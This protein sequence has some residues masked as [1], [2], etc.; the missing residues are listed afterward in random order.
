MK[1]RTLNVGDSAGFLRGRRPA[2]ASVLNGFVPLLELRKAVA[3]ELPGLF[4]EIALPPVDGV[5]QQAGAPLLAGFAAKPLT[6]AL[7]YAAERLLPAIL[8]I[9][10]LSAH[11]EGLAAF[12]SDGE[13]M[14]ALLNAILAGDDAGFAAM[15]IQAGL[16][17][18][19][20]NFAADFI[21]ST[22]LRGFA[23]SLCDAKGDYPWDAEGSWSEGYCPVCGERPVIAW[24]DKPD[25]DEANAFLVG[26]GGKKHFHCAFCGV[27]WPFRRVVCPECGKEGDGAMEIL[28]EAGAKGERLDVCASCGSYCPTVDLREFIDAPDMDVM[29]LGMLHMDIIAARKGLRPLKRTFW[30]IF[31]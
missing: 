23:A 1:N 20:L 16:P 18:A 27:N 30:N 22:T 25:L 13:K 24:L 8:A 26:G 5:K 10:A 21:F 2:L 4:P 6:P 9:P 12:F 19:V 3:A 28:A 31:D 11:K 7:L 14:A 17:A 29:V 15:A